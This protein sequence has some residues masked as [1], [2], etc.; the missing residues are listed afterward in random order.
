MKYN[1]IHELTCSSIN[2]HYSPT[3]HKVSFFYT[4]K[5]YAILYEYKIK[6]HLF[7]LLKVNPLT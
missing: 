4:Y 5:P 2:L 1:E 6:C 7:P 3:Q